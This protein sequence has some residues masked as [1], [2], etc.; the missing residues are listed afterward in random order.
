[1]TPSHEEALRFLD[2]A[3][4]DLEAFR[5]LAASVKV[6]PAIALFHAQQAVEKGLKSA[7]FVAGLEFRR[8][9]DLF[10]LAD[11]LREGGVDLPCP[12]ESLAK[13][14][15]YAVLFRYDDQDVEPMPL[16]EADLIAA[17][18]LRWTSAFVE[19]AAE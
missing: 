8:T 14:N 2:L 6:R 7:L 3:K 10:E 19:S 11:R 15:P 17:E 18:V 9:H 16:D 12:V 13:L 5:V 1:M 4:A